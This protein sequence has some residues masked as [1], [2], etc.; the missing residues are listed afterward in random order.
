MPSLTLNQLISF[1]L[2]PDFSAWLQALQVVHQLFHWLVP[3]VWQYIEPSC[4][5]HGVPVYIWMFRR[6]GSRGFRERR[7]EIEGW[8]QAGLGFNRKDRDVVFR[9]Q[10]GE[11]HRG[12]RS[13]RFGMPKRKTDLSRAAPG[14]S[15]RDF[16]A[17]HAVWERNLGIGICRSGPCPHCWQRVMS[18]PVRRCSNSRVVSG[19]DG[20]GSG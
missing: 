8:L 16:G 19:S 10:L 7:Y 13:R 1:A 18:M 5:F 11:R 17:P 9:G 12:H 4:L 14:H 20:S 3:P 6:G 2:Y 15:G